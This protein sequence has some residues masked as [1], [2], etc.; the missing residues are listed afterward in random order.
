MCDPPQRVCLAFHQ[1]AEGNVLA[2]VV[3]AALSIS[4]VVSIWCIWAAI[5]SFA[6]AMYLRSDHVP[7]ITLDAAPVTPGHR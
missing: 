7:S 6:I 4:A 1:A 5:T 2:L 3:I